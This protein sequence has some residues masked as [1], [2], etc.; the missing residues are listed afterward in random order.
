MLIIFDLDDTLIDTSGSVTPFKMRECLENLIATELNI[1]DLEASYQRL[2]SLNERA[3]S[4]KEALYQFLLGFEGAPQLWARI[5]VQMTKP[6]PADF[7]VP[8]TPYAREVLEILAKT[9]TLALVTGGYPP[10]QIEKL[11]K[12]GINRSFFSKIAIPED[13]MKKPFYESLI[14]EFAV[15]PDGVLVCGDRIAMDLVPAHALGCKTVHMRWGRG[16][17]LEREKWVTHSIS[18]LGELRNIL[19]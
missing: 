6:L 4:S 10:F 5:S 9:H 19:F 11:E 16:R 2:L 12:A 8:T 13:S 3:A 15:E 1:T 17:N 18:H 7:C 14:K